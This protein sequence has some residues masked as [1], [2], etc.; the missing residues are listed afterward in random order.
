MRDN[1]ES[2]YGDLRYEKKFII[3][4]LELSEIEHL[5]KLSPVIFHKI[6][7]ERR[8]NNIYMD[9]IDFENYHENIAGISKRIKIRVRWYGNLFG[10][11]KSPFLEI[12]T[13]EGELGKKLSFPLKPFIL[14]KNFSRG[15]LMR[16]FRKSDLPKWLLEKLK[17]FNPTLLNS[18]KRE[19]FI[20]FDKKHRITLDKD[21][22][23]FRI[24]N[25]NNS[26]KEKISDKETYIFELKYSFKDSKK[27]EQIIQHF[28]FRL[29]ASSK[30]VFGIKLLDCS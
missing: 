5:I 14:D 8:V 16:V 26:F 28:P 3:T 15:L 20:H 19:Y 6:F 29:T 2:N 18:Y 12:K 22:V 27:A 17:L 7:Y 4:D 1:Q 25:I 23:F 11:I 30:Y 13:K 24:K 9:S 21:F 10:P